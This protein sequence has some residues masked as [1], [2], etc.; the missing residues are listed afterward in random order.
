[1]NR[2]INEIVEH[3]RARVPGVNV[4]QLQVKYPGADDDGLW[5]F[6]LP[7]SLR[8]VQIESADGNCPFWIE[9]DDMKTSSEA[10]TARTIE[11][12]VDEV[13]AYLS[14]VRNESQRS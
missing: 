7:D 1:M 3:V 8:E 14:S 12:V 6:R 2:D 10:H 4:S 13:V 9:N 11:D 5:F